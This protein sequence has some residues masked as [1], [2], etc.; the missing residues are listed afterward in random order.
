VAENQWKAMV[1]ASLA[2]DYDFPFSYNEIKLIQ[3]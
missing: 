2:N 3:N 1:N